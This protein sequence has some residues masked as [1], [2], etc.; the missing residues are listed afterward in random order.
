MAELMGTG[1]EPDSAMRRSSCSSSSS[2]AAGSAVG[3]RMDGWSNL[4]RDAWGSPA[5]PRAAPQAQGPADSHHTHRRLFS[6]QVSFSPLRTPRLG[7]CQRVNAQTEQ[8]V[9]IRSGSEGLHGA[10]RGHLNRVLAGEGRVGGI[11][12]GGRRGRCGGAGVIP[13]LG[14]DEREGRVQDGRPGVSQVFTGGGGGGGGVNVRQVA[15]GASSGGGRERAP[16]PQQ[17]EPAAAQ[18]GQ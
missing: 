15:S 18:F 11:G 7:P 10:E 16:I 17:G 2:E 6:T 13:R 9:Q 12:G 3:R 14:A 8:Q 4:G 1:A 5:P